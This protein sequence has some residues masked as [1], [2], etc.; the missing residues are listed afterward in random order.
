[1]IWLPESGPEPKVQ[2]IKGFRRRGGNFIP[3]VARSWK[4]T[5]ITALFRGG[6]RLLTHC[7]VSSLSEGEAGAAIAR[8]GPSPKVLSVSSSAGSW[9]GP[10]VSPLL[11]FASDRTLCRGRIDFRRVNP[12]SFCVCVKRVRRRFRLQQ[13]SVK[14]LS[15]ITSKWFE[16]EVGFGSRLMY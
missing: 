11:H 16:I 9:R 2:N 1:M 13:F 10:F 15:L 3:S 8:P 12:F 6:S 7:T 4:A 14:A 5:L